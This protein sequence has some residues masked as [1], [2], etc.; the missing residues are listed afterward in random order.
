M[1]GTTSGYAGVAEPE[2]GDDE[3]GA[4]GV[5]VGVDG[6]SSAM[7]AVQWAT[8]EARSAALP[9]RILHA[10]PYAAGAAT[11]AGRDRAREVLSA[12]F[13]FAR[14]REPGIWITTRCSLEPPVLALARAAARARLLVLGGADRP[15]AEPTESVGLRLVETARCPVV[16]VQGRTRTAADHRPV[17]AGVDVLDPDAPIVAGILAVAVDAARRHG[18]RLVVLHAGQGDGPERGLARELTARHPD[19]DVRQLTSAAH[20]TTALLDAARTAHLLVIGSRGRSAPVRVRLGSTCRDV[21][22]RSH[23]PVEV[24]TAPLHGPRTVETVPDFSPLADDPHDR[25]QLW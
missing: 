23:V 21:L 14:R 12:A 19:L 13:T 10:A 6:S 20:P 24:V 8:A 5:V 2:T 17:V 16:V 18:S 9:L 11:E 22:R 1:R 7:R 15:N 25:R 3:T 4:L